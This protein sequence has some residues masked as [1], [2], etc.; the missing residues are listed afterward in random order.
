[1]M[2]CKDFLSLVNH[3]Y[4]LV[5]PPFLFGTSVPLGHHLGEGR[6]TW[7]GL[8]YFQVCGALALGTIDLLALMCGCVGSKSGLSPNPLSK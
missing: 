7:Q 3:S 2:N 4:A 5:T 6:S 8:S 1:M